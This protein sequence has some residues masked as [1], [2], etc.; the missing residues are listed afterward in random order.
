MPAPRRHLLA[1]Q[2]RNE[3]R[4]ACFRSV[5]GVPLT[6]QG[7]GDP[8][9]RGGNPRKSPRPLFRASLDLLPSGGVRRSEPEFTSSLAGAGLAKVMRYWLQRSAGKSLTR[10]ESA[11]FGEM[12]TASARWK[13]AGGCG[14]LP[15][16]FLHTASVDP[17]YILLTAS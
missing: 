6:V 8:G 10:A 9:M 17:P 15:S 1:S 4:P 11:L 2:G 14:G 7:R 12:G 13:G 3:A 5:N 16:Y